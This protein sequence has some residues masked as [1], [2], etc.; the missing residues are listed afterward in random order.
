MKQH[1][2]GY[3]EDRTNTINR[4]NKEH[5]EAKDAERKAQ[6][7]ATLNMYAGINGGTNKRRKP[8]A[9]TSLS[10]LSGLVTHD[11]VTEQP[12]PTE[13]RKINI[14]TFNPLTEDSTGKPLSEDD[15]KTDILTGKY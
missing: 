2:T 10:D 15:Q 4:M 6:I 8:A 1:Y 5:Q 3:N 11:Q 13:S 9:L 12:E 14:D 7:D